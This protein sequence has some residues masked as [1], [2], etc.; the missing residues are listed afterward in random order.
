MVLAGCVAISTPANASVAFADWSD[1]RDPEARAVYLRGAL[2]MFFELNVLY[3][4]MP[5]RWFGACWSETGMTLLELANRIKAFG[6]S[7]PR[8]T[9]RPMPLLIID[10]FK[11]L[12]GETPP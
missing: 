9:T 1:V 6:D 5:H 3:P 8:L 10:Y 12:C 11:G 7:Q 4:G 2:D